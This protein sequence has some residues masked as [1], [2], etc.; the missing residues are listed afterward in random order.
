MVPD[1]QISS[2]R[3][4]P[5]NLPLKTQ[6]CSKG[7]AYMWFVG[8]VFLKLFEE[9]VQNMDQNDS[10]PPRAPGAEVVAF[11]SDAAVGKDETGTAGRERESQWKI[12][13]SDIED[14]QQG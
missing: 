4:P 7:A 3:A 13:K 12:C 9:W 1:F 6:T 11:T 2:P 8:W 5:C 10:C 14:T